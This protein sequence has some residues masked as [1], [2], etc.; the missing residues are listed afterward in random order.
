MFFYHALCFGLTLKVFWALP[1]GFHASNDIVSVL[2]CLDCFGGVL[3]A[4]D[5]L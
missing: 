1:V 5:E 2:I 4:Q 3:G